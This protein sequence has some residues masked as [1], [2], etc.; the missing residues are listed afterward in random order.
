MQTQTFRVVKMTVKTGCDL[1]REVVKANLPKAKAVALR[2]TLENQ[3]GAADFDP[4]SF[5]SYLMEPAS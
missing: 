3:N 2:D 5:A 4:H 1:Q